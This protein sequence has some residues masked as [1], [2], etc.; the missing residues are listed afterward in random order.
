MGQSSSDKQTV[1]HQ[2]DRFCKMV[3]HGE[4]V[5]YEKEMDYRSKYEVSFSQLTEEE[6][7]CL[8]TM[9]EYTTES[10]KFRVLDYDIE[11][12]DKLLSEALKYLPE[13]KRNVILMSFF[14][15]M[16]DT[17]IAKQMNLVRSTIHHHRVS[18]LQALKQIMEGIRNGEIK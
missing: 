5:N 16:T 17:E 18:S 2:F 15:D 10:E 8:S 3:L 6:L 7:R 11:V 9:D 1:R 12:K 13:K 4:K 14:M